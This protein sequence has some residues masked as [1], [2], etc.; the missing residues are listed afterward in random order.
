MLA[1]ILGLLVISVAALRIAWLSDDALITLRH[2]LNITH[3]W[4]S[5]YN[6]TENDQGYTHPL[7]FL[8]WL[9]VGNT[10][11]WVVGILFLSVLLTAG[12]VFL[13][14]RA[15][16]SLPRVVLI[17]GLLLLSNAFME[18]TTSGLENPLAFLTLGLLITLTL[19]ARQS[20]SWA[21]AVGLTSAAIVL[22]RFDLF[23]LII[24]VLLGIV[25]QLRHKLRLLAVVTVA[26]AVPIVVWFVWSYITYSSLLPNTFAAKQNAEIPRSELVVQGFRYLWVT[27]EHDP[28]SLVALTL[29]IGAAIL[30]GPTLARLWTVGVLIYLSYVVAIGG[31]FMAGRFIAVPVYVAVF[32]LGFVRW[33]STER[34]TH[35]SDSLVGVAGILLLILLASVHTGNTPTSLANGQEPRWEVDQN[36][37]AGVSDERGIYVANGRSLEFFI[38]NLSLGYLNPDF[39]PLGDGTGLNRSL[40]ELNKTAMN[41]PTRPDEFELPSEVGVLCGF[42]GT[43]GIAV[44]PTVHLVDSCALTDRFLAQQPFQPAEPFAWKPGHFHREVPEGYREAL[45]FNDPSQMADPGDAFFLGQLWERIR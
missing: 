14:L 29:G 8:L 20:T 9:L 30:M 42:M 36:F 37:N 38:D 39:A 7:W 33:R 32:T 12:A 15:A 45:L 35:A 6:A 40:R 19:R 22:T 24:P 17:S 23:F 11:Q 28:I 13:A 18:Y 5:G 2:A 10:S 44:G 1:R 25:W 21:I 34:T 41:W 16:T 27:F 31:D 3:G 43:V 26:G 4:S